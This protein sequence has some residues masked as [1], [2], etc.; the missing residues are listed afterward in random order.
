MTGPF[1]RSTLPEP[2]TRRGNVRRILF[3]VIAAVGLVLGLPGAASAHSTD[4]WYTASEPPANHTFAGC[5]LS[6][7]S[8][9]YQELCWGRY[10]NWFSMDGLISDTVTDGYCATAQIRYEIYENG[11]W[12]GH[13]HYRKVAGYDCTTG[14]KYDGDF[15][16]EFI[17]KYQIRNISSR[18][19][20]ADSNG[21][22]IHCESNWHALEQSTA[23][24]E[25]HGRPVEFP[26]VNGK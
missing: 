25:D 9:V 12:A 22:I 1:A 23:R 17:S 7:V 6:H 16:G 20:H 3:A 15:V 10:G 14:G 8:G 24:H 21:E 19:C 18:A 5:S 26:W 2:S 4:D 13:W 11:A